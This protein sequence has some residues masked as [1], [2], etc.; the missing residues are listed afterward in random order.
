MIQRNSF[1]LLNCRA[2]DATLAI[3]NVYGSRE[4]FPFSLRYTPP[5]ET[6]SEIRRYQLELQK[7]NPLRIAQKSP[8]IDLTEWRS[9]PEELWLTI[10]VEYLSDTS[11]RWIYPYVFTLQDA[12]DPQVQQMYRV[13]RRIMP[14]W[15]QVDKTLK[16]PHLLSRYI[17]HS[18]MLSEVEAEKLS[19]LLML[20][21]F[22][23]ELSYC[24]VQQVCEEI[25]MTWWAC[26]GGHVMAFLEQAKESVLWLTSGQTVE[27]FIAGERERG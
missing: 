11:E 27:K 24:F 26:D 3:R 8:V 18:A 14:G 7:E 10:F 20:P 6:F 9:H 16:N 5:Y 22:R 15:I 13:L 12:T 1:C 25:H 4:A 17:Q 19:G 21:G 2:H 23:S